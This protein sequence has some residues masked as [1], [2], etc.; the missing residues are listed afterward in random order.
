MTTRQTIAR[1]ARTDADVLAL[2][3]GKRAQGD[4]ELT[5]EDI[6][7]QPIPIEFAPMVAEL[8][9]KLELLKLA[10]NADRA[11]IYTAYGHDVK[12]LERHFSD[13]QHM[14]R[15]AMYASANEVGRKNWEEEWKSIAQS[16]PPFEHETLFDFSAEVAAKPEG[17]LLQHL[18]TEAEN[19]VTRIFKAFCFWLDTSMT[20]EYVGL[21]RVTSDEAGRYHYFR[22]FRS[23][24][25]LEQHDGTTKVSVDETKPQGQRTTY[26]KREG[27][28]V[29]V[30]RDL[31]RHDHDIVNMQ[32]HTVAEYPDQMPLRV[33]EFLNHAPAFILPYLRIVS[34]TIIRE[35][36]RKRTLG[37]ELEDTRTVSTWLDSPA[38]T[39]ADY[40]PVGWSE[41]DMKAGPTSF[42]RGQKAWRPPPTWFERL[43]DE[44]NKHPIVTFMN[45]LLLGVLAIV[46]F[47]A[48]VYI[49]QL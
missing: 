12:T 32:V 45:A 21:I 49:L 46:V 31:E 35:Q 14:V 15:W 22:P 17:E 6:Y 3:F 40:V 10:D 18:K 48:T 39:L 29:E 33:V 28:L 20:R 2:L 25:V 13:F 1:G 7:K 41:K 47:E 4:V 5:N 19:A 8:R 44:A 27:K 23:E 30:T 38:I 34:G 11:L 43:A 36:V 26:E 42:F 9:A 16:M 24:K 37:V